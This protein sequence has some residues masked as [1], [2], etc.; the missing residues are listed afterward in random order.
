M[1]GPCMPIWQLS[2]TCFRR[3]THIHGNSSKMGTFPRGY[4]HPSANGTLVSKRA[5]LLARGYWY[6]QDFFLPS[7]KCPIVIS[8]RGLTHSH[9]IYN[10]FVILLDYLNLKIKSIKQQKVSSTT[11]VFLL[12]RLNPTPYHLPQIL[13]MGLTVAFNKGQAMWNVWFGSTHYIMAPTPP[14][15]RLQPDKVWQYL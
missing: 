2:C 7:K 14:P 5:L 12:S 4:S 10:L 1:V 3:S 8:A 9:A 15:R 6:F 11:E 13:I